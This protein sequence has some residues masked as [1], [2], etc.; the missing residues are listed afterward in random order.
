MESLKVCKD[1]RRIIDGVRVKGMKCKECG[2]PVCYKCN[3][4]Y[5]CKTCYTDVIRGNYYVNPEVLMG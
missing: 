2:L 5:A 3:I 4:C 1:C